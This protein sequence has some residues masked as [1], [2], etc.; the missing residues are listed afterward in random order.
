MHWRTTKFDAN[1]STSFSCF[2]FLFLFLNFCCS[3]NWRDWQLE[4]PS[5]HECCQD[6]QQ[7]AD[8]TVLSDVVD[9]VGVDLEV[10]AGPVFIRRSVQTPG[11]TAVSV[12]NHVGAGDVDEV[13]AMVRVR[14]AGG[15]ESC[16]AIFKSEQ[17]QAVLAAHAQKDVDKKQRKKNE[18]EKNA[19]AAS[20]HESYRDLQT[21]NAKLVLSDV[22]IENVE[23]DVGAG[24]V[25]IRRSV[26]TPGYTA[27]SVANHVGAGDVDEV[28]AMVR[29]RSA[30]GTE[31]CQAIF[32]S[33]QA[34]SAESAD[35]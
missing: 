11:Y 12:A 24:P 26:Q 32:K 14:S 8:T 22:D 9:M 15:T 33:E 10:E 18:M 3:S 19:A 34:S 17:A 21:D 31:S 35:I 27:V 29:V 13:V 25:F 2:A 1:V 30:G 7:A 4:R 16:Q 28:V 23:A 20:S 6:L 5:L